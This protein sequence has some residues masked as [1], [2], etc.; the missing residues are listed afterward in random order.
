MGKSPRK[1]S[2]RAPP[3]PAVELERDADE[4]GE[5]VHTIADTIAEVCFQI[6]P[7]DVCIAHSSD[8]TAS[9]IC[10]L[11]HAESLPIMMILLHRICR[12]DKC[13]S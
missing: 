13:Y 4:N 2:H 9:L 5:V 8:S 6:L 11:Y 10:M 1:D 7:L 3:K 12:F